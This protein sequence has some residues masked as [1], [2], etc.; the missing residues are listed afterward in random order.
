MRVDFIPVKYVYLFIYFSF[1][2]S[3]ISETE[4]LLVLSFFIIFLIISYKSLLSSFILLS[5]IEVLKKI[6]QQNVIPNEYTS[7]LLSYSSFI[8]GAIKSPAP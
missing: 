2:S 4:L 8:S 7:I 1:K 3:K 5:S 6:K